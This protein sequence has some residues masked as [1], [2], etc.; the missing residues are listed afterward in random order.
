[1]G[2][3]GFVIPKSSCPAFQYLYRDKGD[4]DVIAELEAGPQVVAAALEAVVERGAM[5]EDEEPLQ[6]HLLLT[7]QDQ[8]IN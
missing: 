7:L 6:D 5:V 8:Q 1:M 3:K 2:S 4:I